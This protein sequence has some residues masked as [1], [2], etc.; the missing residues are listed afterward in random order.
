MPPQESS[1]GTENPAVV[2]TTSGGGGAASDSPRSLTS[3]DRPPSARS[4]VIAVWDGVKRYIFFV[5]G[6]VDC[7][8]TTN[9]INHIAKHSQISFFPKSIILPVRMPRH[10]TSL[11]R[12]HHGVSSLKN[13]DDM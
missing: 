3:Q 2:A 11:V 10:V 1:N 6:G 13:R 4:S 9:D 5:F 7:P 8:H 12:T